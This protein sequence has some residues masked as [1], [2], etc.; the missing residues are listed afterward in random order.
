MLCVQPR[1][2]TVINNEKEMNLF[3]NSSKSDKPINGRPISSNELKRYYLYMI[4]FFFRGGDDL[5]AY[6]RASG[7]DVNKINIP[8]LRNSRQYYNNNLYSSF[9][10]CI[11]GTQS[12]NKA[13]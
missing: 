10:N 1:S 9:I 3:S 13:S 4:L 11:A 5:S 7:D 8:F 12:K 2:Q 6:T